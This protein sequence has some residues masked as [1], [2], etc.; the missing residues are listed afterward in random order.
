MR[1][2]KNM[3]LGYLLVNFSE[4]SETTFA[5]PIVAKN[6]ELHIKIFTLLIKWT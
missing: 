2:S 4:I 3:Q 1:L 6:K 5:F